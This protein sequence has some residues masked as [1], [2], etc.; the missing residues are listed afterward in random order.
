MISSGV[1]GILL[2][3][4]SPASESIEFLKKSEVPFILVNTI[5]DDPDVSYMC[6]DNRKGGKMIAEYVNSLHREQTIVIVGYEHQ[7]VLDRI[8]GFIENIDTTKSELIKYTKVK[9]YEDGYELV[10]ILIARNSIKTVKTTLFIGND[11]VAI[12]IISRLLE[13][14]ISVPDQASVV[15]FDDI[16]LSS[17][18][19]VPLMTVSQSIRNMGRIAA[20]D[21]LDMIKNPETP[22]RKHIIEP[23]LIIRE[24]A[25]ALQ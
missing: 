7:T 16:R 2:A 15:G 18:C 8:E 5:S 17:F 13:M 25:V 10:S 3:P 21:L 19:R 12:G 24:S 9:T 1:D 23:A 6:C 14:N 11:N 20:I 22:P 4:V